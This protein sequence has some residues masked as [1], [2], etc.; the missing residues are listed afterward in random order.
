MDGHVGGHFKT[1]PL[2]LLATYNSFSNPNF[3]IHY[4]S[5]KN[6]EIFFPETAGHFLPINFFRKFLSSE[7]PHP[8][9]MRLHQDHQWSCIHQFCATVWFVTQ[10]V[11]LEGGQHQ[12]MLQG[13]NSI[14]YIMMCI[15]MSPDWKHKLYV[16]STLLNIDLYWEAQSCCIGVFV[17]SV[18]QLMHLSVIQ[19]RVC[20]SHL[21]EHCP[22]DRYHLLCL[23]KRVACWKLTWWK[24]WKLAQLLLTS[25]RGTGWWTVWGT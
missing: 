6:L 25:V 12:L 16:F 1:P 9:Q 23:C 3:T 14:Q 21:Q 18:L 15:M 5:I 20:E 24:K 11:L 22:V 7:G 8:P 19:L 2:L 17:H 13:L 4:F 10:L